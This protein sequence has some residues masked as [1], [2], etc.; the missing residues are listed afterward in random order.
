MLVWLLSD[1]DTPASW[2]LE[3]IG[4]DN[5]QLFVPISA[6]CVNAL[7]AHWRDRGQDFDAAAAAGP[8]GLPL[9]ARGWCRPRRGLARNSASP[10]A[11]ANWP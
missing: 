2:L 7:R 9:I 3:V 6:E 10:M 4:N 5:K 1:D 8:P 11:P